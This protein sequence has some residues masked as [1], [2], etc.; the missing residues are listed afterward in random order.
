MVARGVNPAEMRRAAKAATKA[1]EA[2]TFGCVAEQ[3]LAAKASAWRSARHGLHWIS[4]VRTYAA[5][6]WD[7]PIS[8]ITDAAARETVLQLWKAI[9]KTAPRVRARFE[10]VLDHAKA[11]GW[12]TGE[13]PFRLKGNLKP[14]L[15]GKKRLEQEHFSALDYQALPQFLAGLRQNPTTAHLCLEFQTITA[16][17]PSE[18]RCALWSEIDLNQKLWVIPGARMKAGAE[19]VIPLPQRALQDLKPVAATIAVYFPWA[20]LEASDL[21]LDD[22]A[23]NLR[24]RGHGARDARLLPELVRRKNRFPARAC[25][26]DFSACGR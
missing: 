1:P 5:A 26:N 10:L 2:P 23:L 18:A 14:V 19:H 16:T 6:I 9:P 25:R 17:R 20:R 15:P 8:T 21:S 7:Q 24:C 4:S 12:Y 11:H 3:V 22:L 13:N